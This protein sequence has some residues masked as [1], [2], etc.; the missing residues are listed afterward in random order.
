M[1]LSVVDYLILLLKDYPVTEDER[2]FA[3][4]YGKTLAS[5]YELKQALGKPERGMNNTTIE[6]VWEI[7]AQIAIDAALTANA[8]EKVYEKIIKMEEA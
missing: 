6:R 8:Y 2:P 5:V 3:S 7:A 1:S 4:L